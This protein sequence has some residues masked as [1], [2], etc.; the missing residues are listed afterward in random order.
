VE[1]RRVYV[2]EAFQIRQEENYS[3]WKNNSYALS[4]G[5]FQATEFTCVEFAAIFC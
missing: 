3:L 2:R 1:S 4:R 5:R